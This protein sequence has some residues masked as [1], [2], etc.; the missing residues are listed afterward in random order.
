MSTFALPKKAS[1]F[2]H[3]VGAGKV[4]ITCTVTEDGD[5]LLTQLAREIGESKNV[6]LRK[7]IA[8]RAATIKTGKALA[9]KAAISAQDRQVICSAL[10]LPVVLFGCLFG[11]IEARRPR[12][13]GA[14]AR[15]AAFAVRKVEVS[16]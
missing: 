2:T 4:N 15:A 14:S 11:G 10:L 6:F 9:L 1:P 8:M 5:D 3:S 13:C 12:R 16:A 7:A